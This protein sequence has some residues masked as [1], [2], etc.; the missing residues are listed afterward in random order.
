MNELEKIIVVVGPTASGKSDFAVDLALKNNG[1]IISADSRQVYKYLDIGTGKITEEEMRGVKHHMLSV[2]ELDE[3]VSVARFARD[4][5]P[6][7][8]DILSRG[9]TPIICGGTGQYIDALI[10]DTQ[11]PHVGP[12]KKLRE[13]LEKLKTEELVA[14]LLARDPARA[15]AIDPHNRPRLIRALEIV[16]AIGKVPKQKTPKLLYNT[17]IY[18]LNPTREILRERITKRLE[19]RLAIGMTDEVKNIM[20]RGYNSNSMKK[21]GLEYVAIA[22]FL[23]NKI[24]EKTQPSLFATAWQSMKQEIITKS[25]QYAKRQQT[26]NKK[27]MGNAEVRS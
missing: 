20:A 21:F 16:E 26:W 11:I 6:I 7:L 14:R 10:F 23:E 8:K 25:M 9:K 22:K 12:N 3:E 1:E 15:S 24:D 27:Y 5:I 2:Y 4:T 18:L 13:E 19:K 17:K